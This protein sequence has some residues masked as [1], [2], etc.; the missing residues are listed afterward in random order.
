MAVALTLQAKT[1]AAFNSHRRP[2][3][4]LYYMKLF[5]FLQSIMRATESV[6]LL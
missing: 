6:R 4:P 5:P 3:Q 1:E 2:I